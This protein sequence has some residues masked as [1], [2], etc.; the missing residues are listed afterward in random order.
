LAIIESVGPSPLSF[1]SVKG[2]RDRE[3]KE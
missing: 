3:E 1:L 2:N